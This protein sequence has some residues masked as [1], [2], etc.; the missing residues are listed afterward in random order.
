MK[1][2]EGNDALIIEIGG[3]RFAKE[4][5]KLWIFN[6]HEWRYKEGDPWKKADPGMYHHLHD[7][8]E[9]KIGSKIYSVDKNGFEEI[10]QISTEYMIH[11]IAQKLDLLEY[12]GAKIYALREHDRVELGCEMLKNV[13]RDCNM[14]KTVHN[15]NSRALYHFQWNNIIPNDLLKYEKEIKSVYERICK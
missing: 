11:A 12:T 15:T 5:Y 13:L 3:F 9:I 1:K 6:L 4:D 10:P 14:L 2:F 8:H 7:Y